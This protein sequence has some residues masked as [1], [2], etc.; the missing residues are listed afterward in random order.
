MEVDSRTLARFG[1]P[2]VE[3]GAQPGF[4]G[5]PPAE[6]MREC[7]AMVR[8]VPSPPRESAFV[9]G[10]PVG[11]H[12]RVGVASGGSGEAPQPPATFGNRFAIGEW[13]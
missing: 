4:A 3:P 7:C 2:L 6:L 13:R 5:Q 9:F 10:N 1:R 8:S 12:A 11:V